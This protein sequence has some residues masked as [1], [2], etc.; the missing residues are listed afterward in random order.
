MDFAKL[1][2]CPSQK[3]KKKKGR[4]GKIAAIISLDYYD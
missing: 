2:S 1:G 3:K 4:K